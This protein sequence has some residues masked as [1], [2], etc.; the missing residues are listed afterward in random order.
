MSALAVSSPVDIIG[1][2][3]PAGTV[4]MVGNCRYWFAEGTPQASI[5]K[6]VAKARKVKGEPKYVK[7]RPVMTKPVRMPDALIEA[8][9][10]AQ[11]GKAHR[12]ANAPVDP[13]TIPD[14]PE[15]S[16]DTSE[17]EALANRHRA[18]SE[19]EMALREELHATVRRM[20]SEGVSQSDIA[21]AVGWHRQNVNRLL[22]R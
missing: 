10:E 6:L 13:V 9:R 12:A 7:W 5:D 18:A 11:E 22:K 3:A 1:A 17:L 14:M 16:V 20:A 4:V 2:D 21:R 8:L 19:A 15:S